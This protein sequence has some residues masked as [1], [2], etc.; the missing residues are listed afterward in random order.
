MTSPALCAVHGNNLQSF[1]LLFFLLSFG[2]GRVIIRQGHVAQNFYLI[3]S[4]TAVVTKV[5]HSKKTGE[6]FSK[7]VAL[8]KKGKY[9][10]VSSHLF[11]L[12][13]FA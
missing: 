5:S 2:P 3:L 8:L 4:G 7:T 13:P 12:F 1:V 11:I 6:L 9:F 10:G